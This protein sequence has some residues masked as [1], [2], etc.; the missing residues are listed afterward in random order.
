MTSSLDYT[1]GYITA[2]LRMIMMPAIFH[3]IMPTFLAPAV[4]LPRILVTSGTQQYSMIYSVYDILCIAIFIFTSSSAY[5]IYVY[6]VN[7]PV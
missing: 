5:D 4:V 7:H 2:V 6:V 3:E 1:A